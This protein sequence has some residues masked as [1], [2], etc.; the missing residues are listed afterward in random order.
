MDNAS[1]ALIMAG[2][3]LIAILIISLSVYMLTTARGVADASERR[4]TASQ[5]E[6]FNRF[7]ISYPDEITGLDVYNII[8]K[9]EDIENDVSAVS[10]APTYSGATKAQVTLTE[11]FKDKYAYSYSY[12][13]NGAIASVSFT[14]K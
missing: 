13:S 8:G 14:K 12:G 1:K 11:N 4:I 3:M 2:G 5:I 6:S 9:I 10:I 7:F